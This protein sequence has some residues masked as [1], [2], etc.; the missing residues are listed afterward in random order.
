MKKKLPSLKILHKM[1]EIHKTSS[2]D[3]ARIYGCDPKII[4]DLLRK[5]DIRI[6]TK[7]EAIKLFYN[8]NIPKKTLGGLYQEKKMSSPGIA[9]KFNC[10][11][12]LIRKR[13]REFK[14]SIRPLREALLLSNKPRYPRHDFSGDLK[15]KAYLI[16]FGVGDLHVTKTSSRSLSVNTNSSRPEQIQLFE[17]LFS[18][19]GQVWKGKPDKNGAISARCYLNLSF[20]FLLD[21]KHSVELW[22]LNNQ[23]YFASY[24]AGYIDAEGTFCLCDGDAVFSIRSQDKEII[25]RIYSKLNKLSMLCKPPYL[26]WRAG[27]KKKGIKS[28]RD[29]WALFIH[30]KD[31]LLKLIKLIDPFLRHAKRR[32]DMITVKQN[33]KER[34]IKYNYRLDVR[35]YKT[36]PKLI[37]ENYERSLALAQY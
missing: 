26:V 12:A 8:I 15:E 7:S 30:R 24:L 10:S 33:I 20:S 1:Y 19:Y 31:A 4:R 3:I 37:Q 11:P 25:R 9:K 22:I 36:Y 14:I 34:N 6:R 17:E 27:D 29:V 5:Y 28:N 23:D 13:L 16:G 2:P 18:N 21:Q 32:R 35:W